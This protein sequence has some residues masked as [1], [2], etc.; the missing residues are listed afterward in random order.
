MTITTNFLSTVN[1]DEENEFDRT[2]T[3]YDDVDDENELFGATS[4][5]DDD[6]DELFGNGSKAKLSFQKFPLAAF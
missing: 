3:S 2:A 1:E 5:K 4:S 6:D